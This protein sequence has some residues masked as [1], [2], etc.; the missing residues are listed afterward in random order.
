MTWVCDKCYSAMEVERE[1]RNRNR[2]YCP[3]C[4]NE[5]YV[6]DDDEYINDNYI[7]DD[8]MPECCAA[9]GNPAY[10]DCQLSCKIFDD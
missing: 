2:V 7:C 8:D 9:C 5:W 3:Q 10:P 4:G 1:G 6:D